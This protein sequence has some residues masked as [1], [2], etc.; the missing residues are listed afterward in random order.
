[1]SLHAQGEIFGKI[2]FVVRLKESYEVNY[3]SF[4]WTLLRDYSFCYEQPLPYNYTD[5]FPCQNHVY[6]Q[7]NMTCNATHT[8]VNAEAISVSDHQSVSK[9]YALSPLVHWKTSFSD[10]VQ[11]EIL[12]NSN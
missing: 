8:I 9:I 2:R 11:R 6:K 12:R 3:L 7:G 4:L 10:S 1:M 5:A